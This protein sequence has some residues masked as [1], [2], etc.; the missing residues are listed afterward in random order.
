MGSSSQ[1]ALGESL[2]GTCSSLSLH[3]ACFHC[4]GYKGTKQVENY[5]LKFLTWPLR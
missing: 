2:T 1:E 4:Q 3:L 5:L